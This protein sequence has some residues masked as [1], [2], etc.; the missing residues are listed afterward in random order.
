MHSGFQVDTE[1]SRQL[2]LKQTKQAA[3]NALLHYDIEW[4]ATGGSARI[5]CEGHRKSEPTSSSYGIAG[6]GR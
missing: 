6:A 1:I 5:I 2:T 4:N 3:L